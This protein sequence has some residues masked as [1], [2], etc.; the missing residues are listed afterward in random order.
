VEPMEEIEMMCRSVLQRAGAREY[1]MS[2]AA[3]EA[4]S[5]DFRS[6][7]SEGQLTGQLNIAALILAIVTGESP[8]KILEEARAQAQVENA[9]PFDLHIDPA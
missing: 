6:G 8:T 4:P 5:V 3:P 7:Y 9:F 2:Q 1:T